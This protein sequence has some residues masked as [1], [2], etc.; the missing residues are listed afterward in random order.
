MDNEDI[1]RD[2]K[3]AAYERK[4]AEMEAW[5]RR[6]SSAPRR[7]AEASPADC[8]SSSPNR[9]GTSGLEEEQG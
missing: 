5:A 3:R 8:Q 6:N 4:V 2:I 9:S 7:N 1:M